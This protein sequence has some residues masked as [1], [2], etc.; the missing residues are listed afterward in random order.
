MIRKMNNELIHIV[1]KN[2]CK[3]SL[4]FIVRGTT[5]IVTSHNTRNP[6]AIHNK[7]KEYNHNKK[8]PQTS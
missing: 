8:L 1:G 3:T 4:R 6:N 7:R 2:N 5:M